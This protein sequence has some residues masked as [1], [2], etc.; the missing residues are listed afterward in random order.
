MLRLSVAVRRE[1]DRDPIQ[2]VRFGLHGSTAEKTYF[3]CVSG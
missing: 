3:E 1:V 2:R